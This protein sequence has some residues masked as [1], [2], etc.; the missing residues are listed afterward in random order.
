MGSEVGPQ[1][2]IEYWISLI[3]EPSVFNVALGL[4]VLILGLMLARYFVM[5][6][7]A[8]L[9]AAV[10]YIAASKTQFDFNWAMILMFVTLLFVANRGRR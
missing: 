8:I 1:G 9:V 6:L 4:G 10:V 2:H 5:Y 3:P 7:I